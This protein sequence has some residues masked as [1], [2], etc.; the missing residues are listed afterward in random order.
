MRSFGGLSTRQERSESW[1]GRCNDEGCVFDAKEGKML[2]RCSNRGIANTI[3]E[4]KLKPKH[5]ICRFFSKI[6]Q[7]KDGISTG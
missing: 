7:E 4:P 6:Q 1:D 5:Y 2:D 3:P